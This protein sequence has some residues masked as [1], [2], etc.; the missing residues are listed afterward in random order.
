MCTQLRDQYLKYPGISRAALAM[1]PT[2]LETVRVNEGML[3]ILLA[4]GVAPQAAAWA[5][6]ALLLYVAAY[7]LETSIAR[8]RSAQDDVAWVLDRDELRRRFTALPAETFPHAA[9]LT[10]GEGHDR[11]DFTLALMIDG[12]APR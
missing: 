10:A 4:G 12:L 1:V 5:I 11:F 2:D 7:C 9:E 8:R 6:D 3:A